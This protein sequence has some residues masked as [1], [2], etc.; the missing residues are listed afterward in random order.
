MPK[1]KITVEFT[2]EGA[3]QLTQAIHKLANSKNKLNNQTQRVT[4]TARKYDK[5]QQRVSNNARKQGKIMAALTTEVSLFRNKLLLGAF[6]YGLI[7]RPMVRVSRRAIEQAGIFESLETRLIALF[8]S[9]REGKDAFNEFNKIAAT[10][11]FAVQDIVNAG[12]QLQA[13]G[14]DSRSLLKDIT[15]L[16]AFMG[17]NATEAANAFGRAFAGGA[18]AA[19][20]LRERGILNLVKS[21]KGI[22]DISK[23]T[24]PE[25]RQALIE[26]I[27]D[28]TQGIAGATDRL[29]TTFEGKY[30]NMKDA[31]DR[32]SASLG[33]SLIP[34]SQKWMNSII[35]MSDYWGDF[36]LSLSETTLENALRKLKEMGLE[37]DKLAN[38]EMQVLKE[39]SLQILDTA[40]YD[41]R[42]IIRTMGAFESRALDFEN[43]MAAIFD[44]SAM[45]HF[46]KE[47]KRGLSI[48]NKF[49]DNYETKMPTFKEMWRDIVGTSTDQLNEMKEAFNEFLTT[50]EGHKELASAI[51]DVEQKIKALHEVGD[52]GEEFDQLNKLYGFY[53]QIKVVV[54]QYAAAKKMVDEQL[55]G[56]KKNQDDV[57]IFLDHEKTALEALNKMYEKSNHKRKETLGEYKDLLVTKKADIVA[58]NKEGLS[59]E[60]YNVVLKMV[61][62]ELDRLNDKKTKKTDEYIPLKL[63]ELKKDLETQNK[64]LERMDELITTLEGTPGWQ[65]ILDS[66]GVMSNKTKQANTDFE[67]MTSKLEGLF[68]GTKDGR[69][70]AIK[71]NIA[72]IE[73]M[74]SN[75]KV[76][77]ATGL[78]AK[79]LDN[80]LKKLGKD[81]E[82]LSDG[83]KLETWYEYEKTIKAQ[84]LE[85]QNANNNLKKLLK[86]Y[87]LQDEVTQDYIK[88]Q[89]F[90]LKTTE[91]LNHE[92]A[93]G[94]I[95]LQ[96][97]N[98]MISH[99]ESMYHGMNDIQK[100]V[101]QSMG[102]LSEEFIKINGIGVVKTF[103]DIEQKLIGMYEATT[104][105]V[106]RGFTEDFKN[107]DELVEKL[108]KERDLEDTSASRK[109]EINDTLN[110]MK[111]GYGEL[112]KE[113]RAWVNSLSPG[114]RAMQRANKLMESNKKVIG[115]TVT[116]KQKEA[117]AYYDAF[118]AQMEDTLGTELFI[119]EKQK[120]KIA[121]LEVNAAMGDGEAALE[122]LYIKT[123][124]AVDAE[125][126]H[127]AMVDKLI[128]KYPHLAE[129]LGRINIGYQGYIDSLTD[130]SDKQEEQ[131]RYAMHLIRTDKEQARELGLL[132][133]TYDQFK[134][135]LETQLSAR[136][137]LLAKT[138][139]LRQEEEKLYNQMV[140]SGKIKSVED[141]ESDYRTKKLTSVEKLAERIKSAHADEEQMKLDILE[142]QDLEARGYNTLYSQGVKMGIIK[143]DTLEIDKNVLAT[144]TELNQMIEE[145]QFT[146]MDRIKALQVLLHTSED[147]NLTEEERIRLTKELWNEE[148]NL[149]DAEKDLKK[150]REDLMN[151]DVLESLDVPDTSGFMGKMKA[152]FLA[153]HS[154]AFSSEINTLKSAREKYEEEANKFNLPIDM[155]NTKLQEFDDAIAGFE[156]KDKMLAIAGGLLDLAEMFTDT[157]S[158]F[159]D[160]FSE[161][162]EKAY[163]ADLDRLKG[164]QKYMD[165]HVQDQKKM[166]KD[167]AEDH[168][169]QRTK[170]FNYQKAISIAEV[171]INTGRAMM[172]AYTT[173]WVSGG[174]PWI[175]LIAAMGATQMGFIAGQQPPSYEMGGL[176]G[177]RRH[178]Q[179]G[180]MIEAERGEFV[181]NRSA[182]ADI[183]ISNLQRM[184]SGAGSGSNVNIVFEGNVLSDDF[185]IEEAIPKIREAIRRGDNILN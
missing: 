41:L 90:G 141:L 50:E 57:I 56:G 31:V 16:A 112:N 127:N 69:E 88:T 113:Y 92:I 185:I 172:E 131:S 1:Q 78:E 105:G 7:L 51:E 40:H 15:N 140:E 145:I 30:S 142:L 179:G 74:K 83:L 60:K 28:P 150:S 65:P 118:N 86:S 164:S 49:M 119:E 149:I 182:V 43:P 2:Q 82:A 174:Q 33:K 3:P 138:I 178:S 84:A 70:E 132:G 130:A 98:D 134:D 39:D 136:D 157:L 12:A 180:T 169:D 95:K 106:S 11:P 42:E 48:V 163:Q 125:E 73:S 122:L 108:E 111:L 6:A 161:T 81:L 52:Y 162:V 64:E 29:A 13:F 61:N 175:S 110:K 148:Q 46:G 129:H 133:E 24:L 94:T 71:G 93:L 67:D 153:K 10:T 34:T 75:V 38:L 76:L 9:V 128:A 55:A 66:L 47:A 99:V 126:E 26:M 116:E 63:D 37:A 170:A 154:G 114:T 152:G 146:E 120:A 58:N 151:L 107:Y 160:A 155:I 97:H 4:K 80:I 96:N 109:Q 22:D 62:D 8:G 181:M 100:Q 85:F 5:V 79:D 158:M 45:E 168:R 77:K 72:F 165:A 135:R 103:G 159:A 137:H 143:K 44:F 91:E 101:V 115:E 176:I 14:A 166:E 124:N 21:F 59:L 147:L 68:S 123:Q 177:G 104:R 167:I 35:R 89:V 171:A 54:E 117:K 36:M 183:G 184:N 144:Q 53:N 25:F 20:I 18:G 173:F 156:T 19:D 139:Q 121:M 27:Q 32:L 102:L 17:T 87:Q 23:L